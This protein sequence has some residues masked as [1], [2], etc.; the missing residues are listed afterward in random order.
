[1]AGK[2]WQEIKKRCKEWNARNKKKESQQRNKFRSN[3]RKRERWEKRGGERE[4]E[5][6][7][8]GISVYVI[9]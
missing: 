8:G 1:M 2:R 4:N 7:D 5:V 3:E 9:H 6:V